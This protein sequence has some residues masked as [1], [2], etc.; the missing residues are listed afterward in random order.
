M[1]SK[2]KALQQQQ[3]I[4]PIESQAKD[5][6]NIYVHEYLIHIGAK[7]AATTFL[8]EIRWEKPPIGDA[9]GFLISWWNVFW[10]LYC[11]ATPERNGQFEPSNEAK[12]F[13][14]Y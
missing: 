13:H 3:Q 9:P 11:A 4:L 6:L 8:N 5:K 10:D 1:Y 14:E 7:N 12:V 2:G